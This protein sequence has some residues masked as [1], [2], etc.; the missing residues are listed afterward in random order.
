MSK[1]IPACVDVPGRVVSWVTES[2]SRLYGE[3]V[4]AYLEPYK[5]KNALYDKQR[6]LRKRIVV[7]GNDG[8]MFDLAAE[9]DDL[10]R[11]KMVAE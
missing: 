6:F 2:G 4:K 5:P 10:K 3:T 9:Q 7:I 1:K 8:R 11:M